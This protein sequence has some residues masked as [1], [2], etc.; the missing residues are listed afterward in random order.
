MNPDDLVRSNVLRLKPYSSARDE[1]E[2]RASEIML[3]A[4]ENP[5]DTGYNRYP[6]PYQGRLKERIAELKA[7]KSDNIFLGN[8]SDEVIDLLQ[9]AFC[10]PGRDNILICPPTYGM[11][12]VYA[13]INNVAVREIPLT[14]SFDL[15]LKSTL[16]AP[17]DST[18]AIFLCSPNNPTGNDLDPDKVR[19]LA[20]SFP[21]LVVVD[22]AY[23]DFSTRPSLLT[24]IGEHPNLVVLQT[25]SKAWGMA[26]IRLGMGFAD[27]RVVRTLNKIKPPYNVNQAT[28]E[29]ALETLK[30][31]KK[32]E[33]Q[34]NSI[35]KE[36]NAIAERLECSPLVRKV[37]PSDANF[38]LVQF[39]NAKT[40]L[41]AL[42]ERGIIVRDRSELPNCTDRL[43]ISIGTPT[44]NERFKAVLDELESTL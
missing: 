36:R 28:Q 7:S 11:Y 8:G 19:S 6:D 33:Q 38:L 4:N 9:R 40:V 30:N 14:A 44:E 43:R 21:G 25:L 27:E 17:D 2:G 34:I 22:E 16:E 35:R 20:S 26:G 29:L 15:D 23:I 18:K 31:E 10:E 41:S 37:H 24:R 1:H 3:D 5:Y 42:K 13:E 12:K 32:R 39:H